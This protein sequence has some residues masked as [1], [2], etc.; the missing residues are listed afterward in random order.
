M[1]VSYNADVSSASG[2]TFFRLLLRWRGSIWKS[3]MLE[4]VMWIIFYYIIFGVY[5]YALPTGAQRC[6][7]PYLQSLQNRYRIATYCDKN[8]VHIPLTFMLGFFVSM[9][10]DRWRNTFNNMGWIENSRRETGIYAELK[11]SGEL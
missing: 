4:L 10:V 3:I 6:V 5:R 2:F 7:A 9:I 11:Q 8:L 1:T